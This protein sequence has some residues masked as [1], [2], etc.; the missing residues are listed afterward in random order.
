[1]KETGKGKSKDERQDK[2]NTSNKITN[3]KTKKRDKETLTY[4]TTNIKR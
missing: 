1:M 3:R 4:T 2:A